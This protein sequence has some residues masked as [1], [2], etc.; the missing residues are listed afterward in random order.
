[1]ISE[2]RRL[3]DELIHLASSLLDVLEQGGPEELDALVARRQQ[4]LEQLLKMQPAPTPEERRDLRPS[5]EH[6]QLLDRLLEQRASALQGKAQSALDQ[7]R[8]YQLRWGKLL[9]D[10]DP[11]ARQLDRR[12]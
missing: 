4:V 3:L 11:T 6:L 1:M 8:H 5:I 2:R 9:Q 7:I 12:V 10:G